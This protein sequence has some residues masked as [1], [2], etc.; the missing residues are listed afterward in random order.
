M[1]EEELRERLIAYAQSVYYP[2]ERLA[3]DI[4]TLIC[5]VGHRRNCLVDDIIL[6][7]IKR[8]NKKGEP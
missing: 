8:E 6:R 1:T 2:K 5:E 7:L 3:D 4:L